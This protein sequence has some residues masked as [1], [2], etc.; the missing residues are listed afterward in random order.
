MTVLGQPLAT[1]F[2]LTCAE[3]DDEGD[4]L[5]RE[6]ALQHSYR[7]VSILTYRVSIRGTEDKVQCV[8]ALMSG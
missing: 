3:W 4:F 8:F 7:P 1:F 6:E 2:F 5:K